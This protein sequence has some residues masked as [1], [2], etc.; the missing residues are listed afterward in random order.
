MVLNLAKD[1]AE[2]LGNKKDF[3]KIFVGGFSQGCM[4]SLA[5]LHLHD[6]P[7]PFGGIIGLSGLQGLK[8]DHWNIPKNKLDIQRKT[9]LFIYH[10][11]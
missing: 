11:S 8:F 6:G 9:P 1:E 3:S 10:G 7:T 2:K 4:V 5:T